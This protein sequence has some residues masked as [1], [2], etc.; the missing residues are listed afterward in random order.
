M[1]KLKNLWKVKE[2]RAK[3]LFTIGMLLL[4]RVGCNLAVPFINSTA[5]SVMFSNGNMLTYLN[6]M[7]GGALSQCAVFALGVTP[8]INAS[9]IMCFMWSR[10]LFT[11]LM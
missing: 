10:S 9:I 1:S 4:F 8:Y 6:M 7:S 5:L 2:L 11:H 3:L